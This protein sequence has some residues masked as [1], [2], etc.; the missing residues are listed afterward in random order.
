MAGESENLIWG[1]SDLK[2]GEFKFTEFLD[3]KHV[4]R[5]TNTSTVEIGHEL[6]CA[7]YWWSVRKWQ[8]H[9]AP[10]NITY[11]PGDFVHF[12]GPRGRIGLGSI[13]D[14]YGNEFRV[15]HGGIRSTTIS[16]YY[17]SP[18]NKTWILRALR[19]APSPLLTN[20]KCRSK[21]IVSFKLGTKIFRL[22]SG[23][24]W[25]VLSF[26]D[27]FDNEIIDLTYIVWR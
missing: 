21:M 7:R 10:L 2:L 25:K 26:I 3:C 6:R 15:V 5:N 13:A 14:I 16:S 8:G 27:F 24:Q 1:K 19:A 23:R 18:T 20:I 12:L 4:H 9:T 17:M 11:E 22:K